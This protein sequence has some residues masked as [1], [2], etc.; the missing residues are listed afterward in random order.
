MP[1]KPKKNLKLLSKDRKRV[2]LMSGKLNAW[3]KDKI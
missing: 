1:G 2:L 3:H